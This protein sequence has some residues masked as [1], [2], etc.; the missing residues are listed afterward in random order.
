[1][2]SELKFIGVGI[3]SFTLAVGLTGLAHADVADPEYASGVCLRDKRPSKV[4]CEEVLDGDK[5]EIAECVKLVASKRKNAAETKA[6]KASK[7]ADAVAVDSPKQ[8]KREPA[9][10]KATAEEFSSST[11]APAGITWDFEGGDLL[12]W[13]AT[14]NAFTNQPTY[15]DNPTERRRGQPSKHQGN[16]WIGTYEKRPTPADPP[17]AIQDDN[18]KGT[19]TS[20]PFPIKSRK[21]SFLIGGGC[22]IKT[23]RVELLIDGSVVDKI[24]GK[25]NESMA[26]AAFN[27][28]AYTNRMAQIRLVD[29]SSNGWG[30]INFDDVRFE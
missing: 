12:G 10:I 17:G 29:E 5:K 13:D 11:E 14:G 28:G 24:T 23:V 16:Y 20:K 30:H 26:R 1:M 3:A 18:P 4:C 21:I 25:C 6:A 19:L 7:K 15:G 22:E 8:I 27:V 9:A 2:K